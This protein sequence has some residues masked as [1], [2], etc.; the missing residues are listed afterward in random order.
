[1]KAEVWRHSGAAEMCAFERRWEMAQTHR[2]AV[3]Q[4]FFFFGVVCLFLQEG[5]EESS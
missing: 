4:V 3:I 5:E 2:V 1:M